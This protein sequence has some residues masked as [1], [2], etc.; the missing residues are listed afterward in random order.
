MS[1]P[2]F[3]TDAVLALPSAQIA[4]MGPEPAIN[5]V[6]YNKLEALSEADRKAFITEKKAEYEQDIDLYR[7]A[8]ELII[9]HIVDYP[10]AR[11]E[12]AKRFSMYTRSPDRPRRLRGIMPM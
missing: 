1:G 8:G 5:A 11:A 3:E 6:Y 2:A 4:V 10:E 12:L 7:L 9:D